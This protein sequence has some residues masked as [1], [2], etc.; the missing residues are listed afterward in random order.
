A[1]L[2]PLF[3]NGY[4][5]LGM[6]HTH[7]HQPGATPPPNCHAQGAH[8]P[9]ATFGDGPSKPDYNAVNTDAWKMPSYIVDFGH[10][11]PYKPGQHFTTHPPTENRSANCN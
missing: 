10:V 7:P 4:Q 8:L 3:A 5:V 1:D 9:G 11:H 6:F 2:S